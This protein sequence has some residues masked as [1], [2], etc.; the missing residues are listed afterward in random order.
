MTVESVTIAWLVSV[1][2]MLF[3]IYK[4]RPA[5]ILVG[6]F[7]ILM[8]LGVNLTLVWRFPEAFVMIGAEPLLE[9][10][11]P[12]FETLIPQAPALW[13]LAIALFETAMGLMI[14]SK[15]I[16]ARLGLIGYT[17]FCV[18]IMPLNWMSL[19]A[20]CLV[21]GHLHILRSRGFDRS[22]SELIRRAV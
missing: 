19:P 2:Y 11:R 13:G 6:L 15:G 14:L 3:C 18:A 9:I 22:L 17:V 16:P 1:V 20:C 4:P 10:Y 5:R 7:Y 8:G 12:I 21:V